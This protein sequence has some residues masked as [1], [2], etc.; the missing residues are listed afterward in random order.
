MLASDNV[1]LKKE[2][3]ALHVNGGEPGGLPSVGLHRV[4][5]TEVT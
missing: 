2:T 5:T 4:D 3:K 1:L